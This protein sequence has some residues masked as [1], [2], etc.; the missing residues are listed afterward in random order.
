[1]GVIAD[2]EDKQEA[3]ATGAA[4]DEVKRKRRK[5]N[6]DVKRKK[7]RKQEVGDYLHVGIDQRSSAARKYQSDDAWLS[8]LLGD[9][10]T[11]FKQGK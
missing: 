8:N 5:R 10:N 7:R 3:A 2:L 6:I 1:M 4:I 9:S 11:R